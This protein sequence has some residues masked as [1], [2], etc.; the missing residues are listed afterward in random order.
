MNF[1]GSV[2]GGAVDAATGK[3]GA[4]VIIII[5]IISLCPDMIFVEPFTLQQIVRQRLSHRKRVNCQW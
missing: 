2:I 4:L 1:A 3:G 5:I